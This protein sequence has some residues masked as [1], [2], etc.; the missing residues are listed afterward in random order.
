VLMTGGRS[1]N[2]RSRPPEPRTSFSVATGQFFRS[3]PCYAFSTANPQ[4]L[5]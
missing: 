1:R 4:G 3:K 2:V 5:I